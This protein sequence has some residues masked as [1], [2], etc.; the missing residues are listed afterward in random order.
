MAT[1][2]AASALTE[3]PQ[4]RYDWTQA[5]TSNGEARVID[6]MPPPLPIPAA[7]LVL[8]SSTPTVDSAAPPSASGSDGCG[9]NW[10]W[11]L[12]LWFLGFALWFIYPR[13]ESRLRELVGR[14]RY[15][16][17]WGSVARWG[18]LIYRAA[19]SAATI[20]GPLVAD[21]WSAVLRARQNGVVSTERLPVADD[22]VGVAEDD[23]GAPSAGAALA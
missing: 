23:D 3:K 21:A 1:Q 20:V 19:M 17:A 13:C 18:G 9:G 2:E 16:A 22:D 4:P 5:S 6:V 8:I 11:L 7:S 10:I 15:E 12:G 14:E